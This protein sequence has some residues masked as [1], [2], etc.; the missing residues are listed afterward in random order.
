[1]IGTGP[2][3]CAASSRFADFHSSRPDL[4]VERD[5]IARFGSDFDDHLISG[6]ER[7]AHVTVVSFSLLSDGDF[8]PARGLV[9]VVQI[10]RLDIAA[11]TSSVPRIEISVDAQSEQQAG[12]IIV[13][14]R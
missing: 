10:Q 2:P 9:F 4:T 13:L 8:R 7:R 1:V 14:G 11:L 12:Y 3:V 5:E 6:E